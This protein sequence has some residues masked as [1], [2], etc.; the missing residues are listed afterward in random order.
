MKA[1]KA[2]DEAEAL[3][4]EQEYDDS[5][6]PYPPDSKKEIVAILKDNGFVRGCSERR[7]YGRAKRVIVG[8]RWLGSWAHYERIIRWITGYLSL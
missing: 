4:I 7:E 2:G 6:P 8:G 1:R 5:L 3:R